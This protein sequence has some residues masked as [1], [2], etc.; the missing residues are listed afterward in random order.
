M[1]VCEEVRE[2]LVAVA[3]EEGVSAPGR[4]FLEGHLETCP[5]CR[6]RLANERTLSAGL[7][8]MAS[9]GADGPPAGVRTALL[10]EFRRQHAVVPIRRPVRKWAAIAA[11]AAAL[12]AGVLLLRGRRVEPTRTGPVEV[13]QVPVAPPAAPPVEHPA[14]KP[15]VRAKAHP[16]KPQPPRVV[17]TPVE[18]PAE[19][20]SDFFEIP[21]VEPLRPEQRA[22]VFRVQLPRAS[23]AAF[24][25]PV[26]GGRLDSRISADVL[27][28]EDGVVRAVRFIR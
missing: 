28:G 21:Y 10:A 19:V 18:E 3:R 17:T 14:D 2:I 22:D 25:L 9:A 16:P 7:A 1:S 15:V 12:L 8:S 20:A 4:S 11:V 23:M 5:D 6:R 13:V 27:M 26:S 24:G